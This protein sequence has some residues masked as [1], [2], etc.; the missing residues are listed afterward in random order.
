MWA[1]IHFET[2]FFHFFI[3]YFIELDIKDH[4]RVYEYIKKMKD[5]EIRMLGRE[6]GLEYATLTSLHHPQSQVI[7]AWLRVE[8]NVLTTSGPPSWKSLVKAL[9]NVWRPDIADRIDCFENKRHYFGKNFC[10]TV[11]ILV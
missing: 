9:Q 1:C 10:F 2:V 11:L 8:D 6:L 7:A 3:C 4:G 5:D